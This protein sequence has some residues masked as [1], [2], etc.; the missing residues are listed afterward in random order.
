MKAKEIGELYDL[1]PLQVGKIRKMVCDEEDYNEKTRD[2]LPSGVK[3]IKKHLKGCDDKIL[4]PQFVRVQALSPTPS[5]LFYYCK[6][7]DKPSCKVR[8]AIPTTHRSIIRKGII[9]KAQEIEKSGE[10]FYR[11]E[12][13]YRREQERQK[14]LQKVYK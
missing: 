9:F 14:R 6:K 2:I 13:V 7:L 5:P 10:K 1:T 3:K 11:H 4:K 8:V 12:V